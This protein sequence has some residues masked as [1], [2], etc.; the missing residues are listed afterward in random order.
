MTLVYYKSYHEEPIYES[1]TGKFTKRIHLESDDPDDIS[2]AKYREL[3]LNSIRDVVEMMQVR[4][5][6]KK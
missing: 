2:Y 4:R 3:L 6:K 5:R 1:S